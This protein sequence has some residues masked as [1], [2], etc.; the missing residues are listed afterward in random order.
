MRKAK[1]NEKK[2]KAKYKKNTTYVYDSKS[3]R[4]T[5]CNLL[6]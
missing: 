3:F 4:N 6:Y 2:I 1:W 5:Y